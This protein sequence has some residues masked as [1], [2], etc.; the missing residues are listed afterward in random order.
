MTSDTANS[1]PFEYFAFISYSR[2]DSQV[3][4]WLH[5]KLEGYRF[6]AD[7]VAPD[8][9]P[10]HPTHLR[11]IVRDKTDLDVDSK[12]FWENI[13]GKVSRSRYLDR[14]LL[15]AHR[16]VGVRQPG[17]PSFSRLLRPA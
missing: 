13:E 11:P 5:R 6:P 4:G 12:S 9:R 15:A 17:N 8:S 16:E 14:A 10:P 7:L 3:A 1:K 2:K